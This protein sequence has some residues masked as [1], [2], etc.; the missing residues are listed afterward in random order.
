[1]DRKPESAALYVPRLQVAV[2]VVTPVDHSIGPLRKLAP[3]QTEAGKTN[4]FHI[5]EECSVDRIDGLHSRAPRVEVRQLCQT[6]RS[7]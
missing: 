5:L 1:M 7:L 3:L 4:P 6:D 2:E